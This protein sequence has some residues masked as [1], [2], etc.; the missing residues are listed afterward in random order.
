MYFPSTVIEQ[1]KLDPNIHDS[2]WYPIF[3]KRILKFIRP[4]RNGSFNVC[5]FVSLK[6]LAWLRIGSSHLHAFRHLRGLSHLCSVKIFRIHICDWGKDTKSAKHFLLP[7]QN[8]TLE[9]QTL[10][11]NLKDIDSNLVSLN[12]KSLNERVL[13][14]DERFTDVSNTQLLVNKTLW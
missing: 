11:Y 8:F 14:D 2:P 7:C 10:V 6:Y 12:E 13:C 3:K 4:S 1:N 9:R 5:S